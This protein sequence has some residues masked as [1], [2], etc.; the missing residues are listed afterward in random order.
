[1]TKPFLIAMVVISII[2]VAFSIFHGHK[3]H[4]HARALRV[5]SKAVEIQNQA[6]LSNNNT[7]S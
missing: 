7:I 2:I 3:S 6:S 5:I 1:M 4:S